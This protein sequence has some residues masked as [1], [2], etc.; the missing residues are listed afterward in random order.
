MPAAI[1]LFDLW[2]T[3]VSGIAREVRDAVSRD[4]AADLAVDAE[5]FAA[6][7]RDSHAERFIGATGTLAETVQALAARCGGSP[8]AAAVA[9]AAERRLVLTRRLLRADAATLSVVDALRAAGSRLAVVSDSSAETPL[10]WSQSPLG[11]RIPVT[12]F[13]CV[14]G[15]RKP[16][17]AIYL[18]A[19]DAL[20]VLPEDCLF[21]GDGDG[22]ELS[23]AAALGMRVVRLRSPGD[24]PA[25][26]YDDD[27]DFDG[28]EIHTLAGLLE[29]W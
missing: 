26:R 1:V 18:H 23:G 7:S 3:L 28:P 12:A 11:K 25:D 13:S 4:M 17:P 16:D 15:V 14:V 2:G 9:R 29:T 19:V 21:V 22:H 24:R 27:H 20:Q 10:L 8:S 6:A 5:A